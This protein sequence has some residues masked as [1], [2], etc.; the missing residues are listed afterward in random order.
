MNYTKTY[1]QLLR[2]SIDRAPDF[3]ISRPC[4]IKVDKVREEDLDMATDL[5]DMHWQRLADSMPGYLGNRCVALSSQIFALLVSHGFNADIVIGTVHYQG[6]RIFPCTVESLLQEVRSP[7]GENDAV[8]LHA[9]VTLGGDTIVDGGMF[10]WLVRTGGAPERFDRQY[11]RSRAGL[12]AHNSDM[13]YHPLVVGSQFIALIKE[14]DPLIQVE[15]FKRMR[16]GQMPQD[17]V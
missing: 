8:A 10:S 5:L 3:G 15:A 14:I 6:E 1:L 11:L 4:M 7:G 9:W 12:L 2:E 17:A 16:K 13:Q